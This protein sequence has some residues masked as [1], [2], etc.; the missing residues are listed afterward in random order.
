[1]PDPIIIGC[2]ISTISLL[3][4]TSIGIFNIRATQKTH[5][6]HESGK[7]SNELKYKK[8][9][10][11]LKSKYTFNS[12]PNDY[13]KIACLLHLARNI[14]I[15]CSHLNVSFTSENIVLLLST[16]NVKIHV[17]Q[18][19]DKSIKCLFNDIDNSI[20]VTFLD[21]DSR[22]LFQYY[23]QCVVDCNELMKKCIMENKKDVALHHNLL[24]KLFTRPPD[25]DDYKAYATLG[26]LPPCE[27]PIYVSPPLPSH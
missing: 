14:A 24:G 7:R 21:T 9:K 3:I 15:K 12:N 22:S 10:E 27:L 8:R 1:M 5:D 2:I 11:K 16:Q 20:W 17:P 26:L 13:L 4:S 25:A 6:I 18:L 23:I 19:K